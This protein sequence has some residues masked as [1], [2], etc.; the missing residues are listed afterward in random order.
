MVNIL[1]PTQPDDT[2]AIYIKL[3]LNKKGHQATLWYTADFPTKQTQSFELRNNDLKWN[4][5]GN[6][7]LINNTEFDLVWHRRPQKP[8]VTDS[9]YPE[10]LENAEKEAITFYQTWWQIIAPNAKWVN[11]VNSSKLAMS[12]LFQ[13]KV[14]SQLGLNTP[15]TLISNNPTKIKEFISQFEKDGVIYKTLSPMFWFNDN[16]V[17]LTYTKCINIDDL[18]SDSVLQNTPGIFQKR[19][20]K[21][22]ELRITYFGDSSI[23]VKL[24]SQ[25]HPKGKMDW[26][27][28]PTRELIVE[29][30]TLPISINQF[31]KKFMNKLGL[32]FGCFDFIVTP[33]NEY[34]FLEINEQGQ[35]LWIED[36]NPNIKMLDKFTNFLIDYASN[37][38]VKKLP[39]VVSMSDFNSK[40]D[41]IQ[42]EAMNSHINSKNH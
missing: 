13:L 20:K 31:C 14:A 29:E 28:I 37:L 22:Y 24:R 41:I 4:G 2:H 34:Y 18:P 11:P 1:I 3:A 26:R 21:A 6:D 36:I 23:A 25:E 9:L 16:E 39:N 35:F 8:V 12:K 10:D 27:Y 30:Y 40:V 17:R 19:I 7:L 15:H 5:S 33:E 38:E 42:Q 32:V